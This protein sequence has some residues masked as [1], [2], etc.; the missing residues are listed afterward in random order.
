MVAENCDYASEYHALRDNLLADIGKDTDKILARLDHKGDGMNNFG[1]FLAGQNSSRGYDYG[2][3]NMWNNPF[4]YLIW[5]AIFGGGNGGGFFN[6]NGNGE[7]DAMLLQ[8]INQGS[9]T[10]QRDIDR[11]SS[12]LGCGQ[13]E[14]R[15]ALNTV[16]SSLCQ[17]A[18]LVGMSTPQVINAIQAGNASIMSKMAECCCENRLAICEQNNLITAGFA[19]I[20]YQNQTNTSAIIEKMNADNMDRLRSEN[21]ALQ[22]QIERD[23]LN[24]ATNAILQNNN[25]Q[26]NA[27]ATSLT[28]ITG[29]LTSLADAVAKIPITATTVA[30][31]AT[32]A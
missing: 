19:Q 2:M 3:N 25:A 9:N 27:L 1:A 16:N 32:G 15:G 5:L 14:L 18:N 12:M 6:R 31:T 8:A 23:N 13:S 24:A 28:A 20:G 29:Q 7:T 21:A 17:I 30:T 10:S 26:S 22:R 11:L 4:M